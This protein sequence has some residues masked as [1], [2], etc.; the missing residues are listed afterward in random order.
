MP[1]RTKAWTK[2]ADK[3]FHKA[4]KEHR[5]VTT[6]SL[7]NPAIQDTAVRLYSAIPMA[8]KYGF[9]YVQTVQAPVGSLLFHGSLAMAEF[10]LQPGLLAT[11]T[12]KPAGFQRVRRKGWPLQG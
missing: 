5:P 8:Q 11:P 9:V 1:V 10:E 12:P 3:K 7:G 2:A 6:I 4:A